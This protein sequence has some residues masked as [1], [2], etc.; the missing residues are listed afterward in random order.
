[1]WR[2][3]LIFNSNSL[4]ATFTPNT[5]SFIL[6]NSFTRVF[7]VPKLVD[8]NIKKDQV[9]SSSN[10]NPEKKE[11][12]SENDVFK[13]FSNISLS[14][15]FK[16]KKHHVSNNSNDCSILT[17]IYIKKSVSKKLNL[18]IDEN[19][20][21]I[22]VSVSVLDSPMTSPKSKET[23]KRI[24]NSVENSYHE[25][26][27]EN[28]SKKF[29]AFLNILNE[30]NEETSE[31]YSIHVSEYLIRQYALSKYS[32]L[33]LKTINL[34]EYSLKIEQKIIIRTSCENVRIKYSLL[35]IS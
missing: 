33:K 22:I 31:D 3:N 15:N 17:S 2:F 29:F 32:K 9:P 35:A 18:N 13:Y 12:K 6:L 34:N 5:E 14:H 25:N 27:L 20:S 1:M 28:V 10:F 11:Y 8:N 19:S 16:I 26:K 4:K 30:E 7:L 23:V 24:I 21:K